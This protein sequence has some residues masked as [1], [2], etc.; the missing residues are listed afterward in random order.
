[1]LTR[2][3]KGSVLNRCVRTGLCVAVS[4]THSRLTRGLSFPPGTDE[5]QTIS[6][7]LFYIMLK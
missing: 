3:V 7:E 5:V 6:G 4:V 1:M 2:Q